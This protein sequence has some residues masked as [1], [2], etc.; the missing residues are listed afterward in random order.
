MVEIL[1]GESSAGSMKAAKCEN[2]EYKNGQPPWI[3]GSSDEVICLGFMLDMG[4]IGEAVDRQ[5][6]KDFI[7][8]MYA[9]NQWE[10]DEE[11]ENELKKLGNVYA[12]E[13]ARLI[14][15]LEGGEPVR[16]WYS[17]APYSRCGFYH[18]CSILKNYPNEVTVVTQPEHVVKKNVIVSYHSW[19]EVAA[20]EFAGFLGNERKLTS[21]EIRMYAE[22]WGELVLENAPLRAVV[23]GTVLS[24]SEDFYDFIIWNRL[25]EKPVKE[26]RLIGDI[27]GQ[28]PIGIGDWWYAARIEHFIR[29]G[30]IKVVE[31][32]ENKYARL[33]KG[34]L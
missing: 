24:V 25:T 10:Q 13:L 28:V 21:D 27:L 1:F 22:M 7:Y 14:R 17:D 12:G 31:D 2:V 30:K 6:R 26:C 20:E 16:I 23:N 8:S 9:Q 3:Q 11:Y 4:Y 5:Y 19:N 29:Q 15:F 18:V 34:Y 32:S 33:I